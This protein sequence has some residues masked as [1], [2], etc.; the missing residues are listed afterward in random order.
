M[1]RQDIVHIL[2][3]V[4][5]ITIRKHRRAFAYMNMNSIEEKPQIGCII[6]IHVSTCMLERTLT[7]RLTHVH[8]TSINIFADYMEFIIYA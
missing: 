4:R 7:S 3:G 6:G 5:T 2:G 1:E 8:F